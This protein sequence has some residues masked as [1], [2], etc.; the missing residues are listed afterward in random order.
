VSLAVWQAALVE[1]VKKLAATLGVD[2]H[3]VVLALLAREEAS[4]DRNAARVFR[5]VLGK[6]DEAAIANAA[7]VLGL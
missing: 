3:A 1:E 7:A 4:S 6:A 2:A 5:A